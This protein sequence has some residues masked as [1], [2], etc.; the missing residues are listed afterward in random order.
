MCAE[1]SISA[2]PPQLFVAL[3]ALL[4]LISFSGTAVLATLSNWGQKWKVN[5]KVLLINVRSV[6]Y[7]CVMA[8][9]FM[10]FYNSRFICSFVLQEGAEVCVFI[11]F[12]V[13]YWEINCVKS[14]KAALLL[15]SVFV[16]IKLSLSLLRASG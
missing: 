3:P 14:V 2:N 9:I 10:C 4:F 5:E 13:F 15:L 11:L 16:P 6:S 12:C 8:V 7:F 1:P